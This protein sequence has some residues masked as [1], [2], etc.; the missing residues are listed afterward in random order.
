M[1][2]PPSPTFCVFFCKLQRLVN[3]PTVNIK[4]RPLKKKRGE[5]NED[6]WK[7]THL[8]F[9]FR[10][11]ES[12]KKAQR[13]FISSHILIY[14]YIHLSSSHL[15]RT[16]SLFFTLKSLDVCCKYFLIIIIMLILIIN[17]RAYQKKNYYCF[18]WSLI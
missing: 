9:I 14:I 13:I 6:E 8:I 5:K 17:K 11:Y 3:L 16:S 10:F 4:A 7:E 12:E 18:L 15:H 1:S 2:H